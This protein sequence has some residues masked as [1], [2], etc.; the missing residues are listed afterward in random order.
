MKVTIL[1]DSHSVIDSRKTGH[2]VQHHMQ[3]IFVRWSHEPF[4]RPANIYLGQGSEA[5][6]PYPPGEYEFD[7]EKSLEIR[8]ERLTVADIQLAPIRHD[9]PEVGKPK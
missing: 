7:V 8:N 9:P 2:L 4:P 3:E 1:K 5:K 6:P